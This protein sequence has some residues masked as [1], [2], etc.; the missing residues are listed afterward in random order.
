VIRSK[1]IAVLNLLADEGQAH[2]AAYALA[3]VAVA[4][5]KLIADY[6]IDALQIPEPPERP[7]AVRENDGA[8]IVVAIIARTE[9]AVLVEAIGWEDEDDSVWLP[10]SQIK[11]RCVEDEDCEVWVPTWLLKAKGVEHWAAFADVPAEEGDD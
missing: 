8:W 3:K 2:A 7:K 11:T 6:F 5:H 10:R 1:L 9:K 4:D